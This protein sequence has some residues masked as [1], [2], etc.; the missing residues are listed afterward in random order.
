MNRKNFL[1][2]FLAA[3]VVMGWFAYQK[4]AAYLMPNVPL[5]LKEEFV[6]IPSNSSFEEI[7]ELLHNQGF[8]KNKESF[9]EVSERLKYKRENMRSGRFKIESG[10]NNY[11]LV[12]LLRNGEQAPV[13]LILTNARLLEEIA[14]KV[15]RFIE[16]DSVEILK[17]FTN[18]G[19]LKEYGYTLETL[20]SLFIPN[21]YEFFW[22]TSPQEFMKRMQK[23]HKA[24]WNKNNRL[25]KAKEKN[26]TP[27][28][29]YT[30]AS[31]VERETNQNSEKKRMAGVYMNRYRIGMRLQADPTCV[32]ATRDFTAR[33]VTNYH[34]EF[35]SPYN[36]YLN[37]GLPPG[38]IS[39]ASIPS[40]D[41]VLEH[42]DH[43][44]IYFCAKPDGSGFHSFAKTLAQHNRNAAAYHKSIRNRR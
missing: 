8:I 33:R 25:A 42:E 1:Y 21:T 34:L 6:H 40:I 38:P 7:V 5:E 27:A 35:K 3:V 44:Y 39:M 17:V 29:A 18:P 30:M 32:F 4:Y 15:A 10:S 24:F 43:K 22:N 9:V 36:T 41:A 28:Q 31:I 23:E 14:G 26:L 2:A 13:D 11:S 12:K 19:T 20:P 37:V 16:P